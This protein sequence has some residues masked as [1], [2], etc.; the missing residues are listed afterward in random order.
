MIMPEM[1][2][3]E[4]CRRIKL[5]DSNTEVIIFSGTP[6]GVFKYRREFIESG[7]RDEILR[8]PLSKDEML[9]VTKMILDERNSMTN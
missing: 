6:T 3:A 5:I 9:K 7:G 2:G 8:K 4:L 1:N